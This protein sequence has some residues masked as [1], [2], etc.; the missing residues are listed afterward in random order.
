MQEQSYPIILPS[1]NK[2]REFDAKLLLG[3]VLAEKGATVYIGARHEIH[4]RIHSFPRSLYLAKDFRQPSNRIFTILDQLGHEIDAWDDEGMLHFS[5]EIYY[6]RRIAQPAFSLVKE[7]FAWSE[8]NAQL[9]AEAPGYGGAPIHITGNCRLDL[10]RP[11]FITF[12]DEEIKRLKDRFGDF[13]LINSNFGVVNHVVPSEQKKQQKLGAS[14]DKL[15]EINNIWRHRQRMFEMFLKLLAKL[16]QTFPN[17]CI[18]VR[19]HPSEDHA[20][21]KRAAGG[22]SQIHVL[23]EDS[24]IPWLLACKVM[25]HNSCSTGIEAFLL[26]RQSISF[27]PFKTSV[28]EVEFPDQLSCSATSETQLISIIKDRLSA[29]EP[30]PRSQQQLALADL[31]AASRTG[32]LASDQI[33][34]YALSS[35]LRHSG[36]RQALMP[37]LIG[38]FR[39]RWRQLNKTIG[40]FIPGSKSGKDHNKHRFPDVTTDEVIGKIHKLANCLN[41]FHDLECSQIKR[42]IFRINQQSRS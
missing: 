1:E 6:K 19:P 35:F 24:V 18:V 27:V 37:Q 38:N 20:A 21:W 2:S 15:D 12:Y 34:D 40:H 25:I 41:R 7:F 16:N 9:I 4:N 23:H 36:D 13:I 42:N 22:A 32:P 29:K 30:M 14:R 17:T 31:L 10:L 26:N 3:C 5:K 11:E 28:G 33:A 39:S 8:V